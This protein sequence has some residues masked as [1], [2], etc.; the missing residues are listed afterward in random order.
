MVDATP[1]IC[2]F[3]IR[4][5]VIIVMSLPYIYIYILWC[6]S[7]FHPPLP[8]L[9]LSHSL[10]GFWLRS[11]PWSFFM[12]LAL[13]GYFNTCK[14]HSWW[15]MV[16]NLKNLLSVFTEFLIY[17]STL[18]TCI[19]SVYK[20]IKKNTMFAINNN[21]YRIKKKIIIVVLCTRRQPHYPIL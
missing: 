9:S 4:S 14:Y 8:L 21:I 6:H 10:A 5:K 15:P 7:L 16:K 2:L 19:Y 3:Y 20:K 11:Y 17:L 12:L 1:N 13:C 18:Y